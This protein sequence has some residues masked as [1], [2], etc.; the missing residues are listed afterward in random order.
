MGIWQVLIRRPA[1]A[2]LDALT[3]PHGTRAIVL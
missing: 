1:A 2:L 3:L